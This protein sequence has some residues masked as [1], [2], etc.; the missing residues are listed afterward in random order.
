MRARAYT[1]PTDSP[2]QDGTLD[3]DSTTLIVATVEAGGCEGIGYTYSGKG[4][5]GLINGKLAKA[6][7]GKDAFDIPGCVAIMEREVRNVG[8]RGLAATAIS[9]VDVA[10]WDLKAKLLDLPLVRLLGA[11]RTEVPIY[12]SGGFTNYTD[13]RLAEQLGRWVSE[14]GCRWV[15]MKVGRDPRR[16]RERVKAARAAIG[17][18]GLFVDANGALTAK[19]ALAFADHVLEHDV[20]WFEE[21]VSSDD[22]ANLRLLRER[23]LAPMEIAAGEYS[24][25]PTDILAM[26]EAEA[27][28]VMQADATR[29]GGIS[30]FLAAGQM[31]AA[32]QLDLS[33]HCAPSVHLHAACAVRRLRH[34]EWFHDHVRLE[35]ILF[36]GAPT[37][38]HGAIQPDL[39]RPGLGIV[40]KAADAE[41]Y[42][43]D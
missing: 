42:A 36:D 1:I 4:N 18:A 33:G 3:W 39:S 15:K 19:R 23:V 37:A 30:G 21:P 5:A 27:V 10:L 11:V 34:L 13:A 31:V 40:L 12:G 16:D 38:K 41:R 14:E 22:L 8:R 24:Y 28:D 7:E 26:L 25:V 35:H 2:E 32:H 17:D 43:D 6:I 20:R 29:C 9:A